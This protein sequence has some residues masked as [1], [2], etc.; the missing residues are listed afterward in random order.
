METV[1]VFFKASKGWDEHVFSR[2]HLFIGCNF[3][4]RVSL[5]NKLRETRCPGDVILPLKRHHLSYLRL[6]ITRSQLSS[7]SFGFP[8][9]NCLEYPK[10]QC[11]FLQIQ[12]GVC[13]H[14]IFRNGL[15]LTTITIFYFPFFQP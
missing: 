5:S 10:L 14:R 1:H 11:E 15:V 13:S 8:D 2:C 6:G 3:P 4:V 7:L 12:V 9:E